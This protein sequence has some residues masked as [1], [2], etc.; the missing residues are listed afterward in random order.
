MKGNDLAVMLEIKFHCSFKS[1]VQCFSY[2]SFHCVIH[3]E[4]MGAF[5]F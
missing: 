2:S 3:I 4:N 5:G 1:R